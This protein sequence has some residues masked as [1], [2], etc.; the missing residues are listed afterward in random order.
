MGSSPV[1]PE[2]LGCTSGS[3][4]PHLV[5]PA[6]Q[7][8]KHAQG[9]T[10]NAWSRVLPGPPT[11]TSTLPESNVIRVDMKIETGWSAAS[12]QPTMPQCPH[13]NGVGVSL[14]ACPKGEAQEKLRR[15]LAGLRSP[16]P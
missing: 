8:Q 11:Q 10:R 16:G 15:P 4:H 1:L 9:L 6:D 2:M 14:I 13:Q 5:G 12:F 7:Q 3:A